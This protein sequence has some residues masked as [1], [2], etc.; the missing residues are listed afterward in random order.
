M[1]ESEKCSHYA[2][3]DFTRNPERQIDLGPRQPPDGARLDVRALCETL[4][5]RITRGAPSADEAYWWTRIAVSDVC[6]T[7]DG[8]SNGSSSLWWILLSRRS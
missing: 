7:V 2:P 8:L 5:T 1:T 3:R 6:A 4:A